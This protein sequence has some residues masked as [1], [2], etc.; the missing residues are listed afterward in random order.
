VLTVIDDGPGFDAAI[1][2]HVFDRYRRGDGRGNAGLGL[3]IVRS[4]ALA[5]GG[6]VSAANEVAGGAKVAL[7]LPLSRHG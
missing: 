4:I 5:H 2:G 7:R 1:I 3:A 6:E